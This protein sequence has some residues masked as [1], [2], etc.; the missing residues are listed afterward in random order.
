[1]QRFILSKCE[2]H[3]APIGLGRV[4][5]ILDELH[6]V[7]LHCVICVAVATTCL[8]LCLSYEVFLPANRHTNV[9]A[10]KKNRNIK[11]SL[12]ARCKEIR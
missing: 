1:M 2:G 6:C 3:N 12:K 11:L 9:C 10:R 8:N 7:F 5:L 4:P